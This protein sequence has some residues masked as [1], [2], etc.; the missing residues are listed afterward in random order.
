MAIKPK[1]YTNSQIAEILQNIATAY[2]IKNKN[3]FRIKSYQEAAETILSYPKSIFKLWQKDRQLV[4]DIPGI[5]PNIFKKITY[6]LDKNKLHPD[7]IKAYKNIHPATFTFTKINSIGPKTA[8]IL[9]TKLKFS[10]NPLT[11]LNQL[12][13]YAQQ[14]KIKDWPNFGE[15]SQ[16]SIL[17][18]TQAYLG[19]SRRM[20][21]KEA[22]EKSDKLLN[23]LKKRFPKNEFIT[24]GSLRR[25]SK[26][27]GD[28][29]I[30][31]KSKKS[32]QILDYFTSYPD[33]VQTINRGSKKAS[34]KIYPDIRVDIMLQPA[35]NFISLI[36]HLTGSQQ[37]NVLLRK[38]AL[39]LGYSLS[40]YG[41]KN[42]KTGKI[43]NF[44]NEKN[45]Y[46]FLNLKY[47]PPKKRIG[48][49]EIEKAKKCYNQTS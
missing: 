35:K 26:T 4:D 27:I 3:F 9:T 18:N 38:H 2:E 47:I 1:P 41:I 16:Q 45:L 33:N 7:I 43:H 8:H 34:I 19:Y 31:V 42:L 40:E 14:N 12:V 15:K 48:D 5:G 28:I 25:K 22:K 46:N 44:K 30:A 36:Q 13:K 20:P 11:A 17:K 23:Y 39:S 37:H 21:Y 29:D 6:L 32:K 24:L 10:K 49:K